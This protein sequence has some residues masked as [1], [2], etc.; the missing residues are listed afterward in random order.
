MPLNIVL[1]EPEIPQN[2]GN[3]ARTCSVTG[4]RLHLVKPLG[5]EVTDKQLKRAGMDYWYDVDVTYYENLQEF[6]EQHKDDE[7]FFLSTKSKQNHTEI[8]YPDNAYLLFGKESKGLP[9]W[10]LLDN[11]NRCVRIPMREN[12]R[13]LNLSNSVAIAAYEYYRQRDFKDLQS[14]SPYFNE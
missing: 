7:L 4:A 5:F 13:S 12:I 6:L 8:K 9:E 10:L 11:F 2:T 1:V 14:V 3:I